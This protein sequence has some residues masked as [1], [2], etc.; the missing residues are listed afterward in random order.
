MIPERLAPYIYPAFRFVV[1]SLFIFHGL[2]K[3]GLLPGS[4]SVALISLLG[5]AGIIEVI[6]GSLVSIGL[7][8][9]V[10]ALI[11]SAQMAFAYFYAHSRGARGPSRTRASWPCCTALPSSTSPPAV[12]ATWVSTAADREGSDRGQTTSEHCRPA[13]VRS[14]GSDRGQTTS[15]ATLRRDETRLAAEF[16]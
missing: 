16:S 8:T 5:A 9:R 3:F 7:F 13:V 1:G 14:R 12:P 10:A 2:Q 15:D 6:C 4:R 11:A